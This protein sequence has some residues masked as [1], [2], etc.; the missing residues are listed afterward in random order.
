[1]EKPLSLHHQ[2]HY[3][4]SERSYFQAQADRTESI[5][6]GLNEISVHQALEKWLAGLERNTRI[7]YASGFKKLIEREW[8]HPEM[9]LQQF[10]LI[11]HEAVVDE[12][13]LAAGWS[14]ATRQARAA[15]Y[16]S[17]TGFLQRRTQGIVRKAVTN[18]EGVNKTFYKVRDKVATMALD[19]SQTRRLLRELE[20]INTRDALIAKIM[21][22]GGKR[23][24]EVL[25]LKIDQI[26][27]ENKRITFEQTKTRGTGKKTVVNYPEHI[28]L[29]L[30]QYVDG[31]KGYVFVTR[32][33]RKLAPNQIDRNFLKA[34]KKAGIHFRV[35]PHVLRV[36]LVTRLKELR[37][38]DT[39]I[40]KITGHANPGQLASYDKT[41]MG[42][43]ASLYHHFV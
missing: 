10:S 36:T 42:Q 19:Q 16:I 26:D 22:Q 3:P 28:M 21:L 40:M 39:D 14:E 2:S 17:F 30:K 1:M 32:N 29:E 38:Q 15:A 27:F 18:K 37:I 23:K 43:N 35:T 7:S 34:G 31:R 5:W 4:A 41:D 24:S 11:N 25:A 13:K 33:G 9:S 20:L 6:K 12:I 8:V